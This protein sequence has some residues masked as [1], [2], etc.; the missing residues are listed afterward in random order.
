ML[1]VRDAKG[2]LFVVYY[3]RMRFAVVSDTH[4]NRKS[5]EVAL[6]SIRDRGI[7]TIVHCGDICDAETVR[8]FADFEVRF[9]IGN[10]DRDLQ[11]LATAVKSVFGR[12]CLA[13][14]FEFEIGSVSFGACHGHTETLARLI[15]SGQ[16]SIV[17]HGHSHRR[18]DQHIRSTRVV[19]PG[20]IGGLKPESRSYCVVDPTIES[21]DF[22]EV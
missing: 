10:G 19:N 4:N 7:E 1:L 11:S 5:T 17:F 22:V 16:H 18:K 3:R 6:A 15:D 13:P 14:F 2:L 12:G 20:A 8:L 21:I 9:V